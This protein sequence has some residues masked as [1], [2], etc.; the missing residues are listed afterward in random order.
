MLGEKGHGPREMPLSYCLERCQWPSV[1]EVR[2]SV[3]LFF[4]SLTSAFGQKTPDFI[5]AFK[6]TFSV[7]RVDDLGNA[8]SGFRLSGCV[9]MFAIAGSTGLLIGLVVTV[10]NNKP[11]MQ[12]RRARRELLAERM[13][14]SDYGPSGEHGRW[15]NLH[16]VRRSYR[17]GP[18]HNHPANCCGCGGGRQFFPK[19]TTL[20]LFAIDEDPLRCPFAGPTAADVFVCTAIARQPSGSFKTSQTGSLLNRR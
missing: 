18:G 3:V 14:V 7:A 11:L 2:G 9:T 15:E 1:R 10:L 17:A 8:L 4:L 19:G 16:E 20:Q 13:I 12:L 6:V 5:P